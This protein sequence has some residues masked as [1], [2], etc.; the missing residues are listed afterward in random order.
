MERPGASLLKP[1]LT[2][3]CL[4]LLAAP[5]AHAVVLADDPD[6]L[7]DVTSQAG[8]PA[9]EPTIDMVNIVAETDGDE[10]V[11]RNEVAAP[12][13]VPETSEVNMSRLY[14]FLFVVDFDANSEV[15]LVQSADAV[16]VCTFHH[17]FD[18]L[19]CQQSLGERILRGYGIND[20]NATL[21]LALEGNDTTQLMRVGGAA[22][23]TD[24]SAGKLLAQDWTPTTIQA[25][26]LDNSGDPFG[27]GSGT[28]TPWYKT[29][30]GAILLVSVAG[31]LSYI[32]YGRWKKDAPAG[33]DSSKD[34]AAAAPA[35]EPSSEEE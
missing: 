11:L 30:R 5:T 28:A 3:F 14:T 17:G 24:E 7:G 20:R 18:D 12:L 16:F 22:T 9:N 35:P 10:L 4:V 34:V 31:Y 13:P 27:S 21:R 19:A 6:A 2:L 26:D 33:K 25:Q 23:L 32:A 1:T 15:P 29:T 8:V